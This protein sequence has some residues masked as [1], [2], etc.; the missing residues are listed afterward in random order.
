[1]RTCVTWNVD[2]EVPLTIVPTS[3]GWPPPWAWKIVEFRGDV[4]RG[5][6]EEACFFWQGGERV[7]RGYRA[8]VYV[9][10]AVFL[11]EGVGAGG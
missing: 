11:V 4:G 3:E 10:G 7:E 2:E 8:C 6:E 5:F 9:E 1:L